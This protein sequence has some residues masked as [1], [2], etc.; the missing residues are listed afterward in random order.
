MVITS[1]AGLGYGVLV[2]II[3]SPDA[4]N[5]LGDGTIIRLQLVKMFLG[6][7]GVGAILSS[8]ASGQWAAAFRAAW[9]DY[10]LRQTRR[11]E[12]KKKTSL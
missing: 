8:V 7:I 11:K 6:G 12:S 1:L 10:K 2:V 5:V 4:A 3:W 9:M